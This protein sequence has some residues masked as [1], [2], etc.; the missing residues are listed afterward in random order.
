MWLTKK[1]AASAETQAAAEF[2]SVTIEGNQTALVT[3]GERRG[4]S[5]VLPGGYVYRVQTGETVAVLRCGSTELIQGVV[6]DT[7]PADLEPGEIKISAAG[8]AA[9][10]L[11]NDGSILLQGNVT[12]SGTLTAEEV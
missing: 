10:L 7:V 2:G 8:G 3:E 12:V 4:I 9:I 6:S 1:L 11:K 5:T